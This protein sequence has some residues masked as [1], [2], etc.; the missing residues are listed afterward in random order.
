[1]CLA[2]N[3]PN[4]ACSV[5]RDQ[6]V[7]YNGNTYENFFFYPASNSSNYEMCQ[8]YIKEVSFMPN[9]KRNLERRAYL[10][11]YSSLQIAKSPHM[12]PVV[13]QTS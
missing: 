10:H 4:L 12:L 5:I 8:N 3:F 1:M 6:K 9:L 2:D 7:E 13:H 11:N